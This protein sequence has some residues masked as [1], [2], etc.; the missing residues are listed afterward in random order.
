MLGL[1]S[2]PMLKRTFDMKK[3]MCL[4][5]RVREKIS[6]VVEKMVNQNFG[7]SI[8]NKEKSSL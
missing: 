6:K 7:Q 4:E 5:G 3:S 8:S 1:N 2:N